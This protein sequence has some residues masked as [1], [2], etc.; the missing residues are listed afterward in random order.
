MKRWQAATVLFLAWVGGCNS[1]GSGLAAV[2]SSPWPRFRHD[3]AH[4]GAATGRVGTQRDTPVA[5]AVDS[6]PPYAP[7]VSSPA[8]GIDG[9]AYVLSS[10]GTLAAIKDSGELKWRTQSCDICPDEERSIGTTFSSPTVYAPPTGVTVI[11]F[12]SDSGRIY[13]FEDRQDQ[14]VCTLCF[15]ATRY[16]SEITAARFLAPVTLMTHV[17]TG[18][19]TQILAPAAIQ[20]DI[21]EQGVV[22]SLSPSGE[23]LWTY[24]R[25]GSYPSPFLTP[26][27]LGAGSTAFVGS[28]DGWFHAFSVLLA[29]EPTWRVFVGPFIDPDTPVALAPIT[30]AASVFAY[31]TDGKV[32]ALATGS[33]EVLWRRELPSTRIAASAALGILAVAPEAT[34]TSPAPTLSPTPRPEQAPTAPTPSASAPSPTS[35]PGIT[36]T[37]TP[38]PTATPLTLT[39]SLFLLSK[40]GRFLIL[41]A[42]NGYDVPSSDVYPAIDG[43]V[44]SSP[45]LALDGY[46]VFGSS[47]GTLY[48]VHYGSGLP[49]WPPI[50]LAPGVAI[51]S[52]PAISNAGTIWIGADNGFV[53]RLG[54]R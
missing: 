53:Y 21:S 41:D 26:V 40:D 9:S 46:L 52:S 19:V 17:S 11:Y 10:A 3:T 24:P 6:E 51:R 20:R 35:T 13:A 31:T 8:L 32:S 37:S 23:V 15:D 27:A 22:F 50:P 18:R 43:Q 1:G 5:I 33:G 49:A 12:G 42:R 29:G 2:P 47:N 34:A 7:V 36:P 44:L 45:A 28:G 30:S 4:T 14:P 39:S 16:R 25:A 48:A 38:T 54:G